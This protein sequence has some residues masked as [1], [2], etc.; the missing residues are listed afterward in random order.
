M[1]YLTLDTDSWL[2]LLSSLEGGENNMLEEL[3]FWISRGEIK[4][5]LPQ[6]IKLE[7]DRNKIN[8][9]ARIKQMLT[10]YH[11]PLTDFIKDNKVLRETVDPNRFELTAQ[12]RIAKLEAIFASC[13]VAP[14]TDAVLL[15]AGKRNLKEEAP[16][17][18][19]DSFRDTVNILS[20]IEHIKVKGY[21][22][23]HFVSENYKDF[24]EENKDS[25]LHPQLVQ[26]FNEVGLTYT[27]KIYVF[28]NRN[29]SSLSSYRDYLFK[30]KSKED[31]EQIKDLAQVPFV[32]EDLDNEYL[33]H[34]PYIDRILSKKNPTSFERTLLQMLMQSHPS[35][36]RYVFSKMHVE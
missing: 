24:S 9:L 23:C 36:K 16:N 31:E 19:Q 12:D 20:L 6:N 18:H 27:Y 34:F 8:K 28:L 5:V 11:K 30:Q 15:E 17:H 33:D 32:H 21:K 10:E 22:N 1:I 13:D 4:C 26:L 29:R 14:I 7:W 35:Y 3:L 25:R 2:F